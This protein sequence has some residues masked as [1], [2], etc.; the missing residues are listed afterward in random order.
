MKLMVFF[1]I[2]IN[3]LPLKVFL[4]IHTYFVKR[5]IAY[6]LVV[7]LYKKTA[8]VLYSLETFV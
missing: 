6:F 3:R 2:K 8:Q 1:G 5:I 7:A 4:L